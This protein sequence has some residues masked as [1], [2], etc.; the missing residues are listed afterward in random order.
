MAMYQP[1]VYTW[2]IILYQV[3]YISHSSL[4]WGSAKDILWLFGA[5]STSLSVS[6]SVSDGPCVESFIE[7]TVDNIH[8]S[9]PVYI[10]SHL[11]IER[12]QAGQGWVS[13]CV[14]RSF[15]AGK[16]GLN[17]DKG[18]IRIYLQQF[19]L[20]EKNSVMDITLF[21]LFLLKRVWNLEILSVKI[22]L[23]QQ[24]LRFHFSSLFLRQNF[25]LPFCHH[26][27]FLFHFSHCI[28]LSLSQSRFSLPVKPFSS[29]QLN[30]CMHYKILGYSINIL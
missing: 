16:M 1:D 15:V 25:K 13:L 11:I 23:F 12:Y 22:F 24:L 26:P 9:P 29:S 5:Q 7:E 4:F 20:A 3:S 17:R 2:H 18:K 6:L 27:H 30:R 21:V 8:C 14:L 10:T 19:S 28:V